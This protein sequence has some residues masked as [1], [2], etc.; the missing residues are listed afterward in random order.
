MLT[1]ESW[2]IGS[3]WVTINFAHFGRN[4]AG[5]ASCGISPA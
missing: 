4:S 2:E 1:P 3:S 5:A